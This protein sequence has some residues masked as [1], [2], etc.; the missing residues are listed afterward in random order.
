[1]LDRWGGLRASVLVLALFVGACSEEEQT[2]TADA[3]A[4]STPSLGARAPTISGSPVTSI[5]ANTAYFFQP[6]ATDADGDTLTFTINAKPSWM[7]FDRNTGRLAGTPSAADVGVYR[8][9][10]VSVSDGRT[11]V[12]LPAFDVTV[13]GIPAANGAPTISGTPPTA[14]VAGEPYS[15][16]PTADDPDG[17]A[18]TFTI[19]NRPSWASFTEQDGLLSG[20]PEP[21][22]AGTYTG[23]VISVSDG[24]TETSLDPFDLTVTV[25]HVNSPDRKS[26]V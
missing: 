16:A 4:S 17:D 9:I 24:N 18:L 15:F 2:A 14:A 3:S 5:A 26:V 6:S 11:S 23:I 21:G 22:D 7:T 1:M 12:S 10:V 13:T 8:S 25:P 19:V 20:T